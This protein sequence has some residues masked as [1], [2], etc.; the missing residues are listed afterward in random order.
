MSSI[1]GI[2]DT[3]HCFTKFSLLALV[4]RTI[5]MASVLTPELR[6]LIEA[7][8]YRPAVSIILPFDPKM[9]TKMAITQAFKFALDKVEKELKTNYPDEMGKIVILRL[10]KIFNQ[11]DFTTHNKA[12]AI[13]ASPVF[14][15]VLYL[16][17]EVEEKII[18]D[19]SFEIRDL[20]YS[21]KQLHKYLVLVLSS[22]ESKMYIGNSDTMIRI[23]SNTAK[24]I[25]NTSEN[26]VE[27]VANFSDKDE[28][29]EIMT[30]KFLRYVDNVLGTTLLAYNMP[31]FVLGTD[32]I[33]GHFN[34]ISKHG[35]AVIAYVRGNYEN[36]STNELIKLLAPFV[37]DWKQLKQKELL[38]VI[39]DANGKNKLVA[40]ILEVWREAMNH[41]G[42]ILIVEKNYMFA[43]EHGSLEQEIFNLEEPYNKFSYIK[44]AVDDI[45]EKVLENGGDVEFVEEGFLEKYNKIVLIQY[46]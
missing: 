41:K 3:C 33:V 34:K 18:V 46:Y 2:A 21:K 7:V 6:A 19:E 17:I 23:F 14:E 31:L 44:D 39:E 42:R 27:T 12:I 43:A 32:K 13:F 28:R 29:K 11:L 9:G 40:G 36:A 16:N 26:E 37:S 22:K 24:N 45:I 38:H 15:K 20:V 1:K 30:D 35:N 5:I 8:H 10:K 4:S 25:F